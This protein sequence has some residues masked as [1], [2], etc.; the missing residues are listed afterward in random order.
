MAGVR[1]PLKKLKKILKLSRP[2]TKP[3]T[4]PIDDK[5]QYIS[6]HDITPRELSDLITHKIQDAIQHNHETE[7]NNFEETE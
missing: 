3:Y 2:Y 1:N 6:D 7:E 5:I 4:K